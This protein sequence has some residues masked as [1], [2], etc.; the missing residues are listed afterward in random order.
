[1]NWRRVIAVSAVSE[2]RENF[3]VM[4]IDPG[5]HIGFA[6]MEGTELKTAGVL[7]S[8]Y[9]N[10]EMLFDAMLTFNV[11]EVVVEDFKLYPWKSMEQ[12]W[13]QMETPRIIGIIE[14]WGWKN[15]I[16]II[17]QPAS[18]KQAFPDERLKCEGYYVENKHARD[19]IRHALYYLK[20]GRR[21]YA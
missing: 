4:A 13:S 16:P 6:Y 15:G 11:D 9:S 3:K 20:F 10:L 1:M 5:K 17:L 14:Y 7:L 21:E 19:A 12:S 2:A 18:V 8:E